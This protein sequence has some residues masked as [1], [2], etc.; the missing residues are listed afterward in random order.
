MDVDFFNAKRSNAGQNELWIKAINRKNPDGSLWYPKKSDLICSSHFVNGFPSKDFSNPDYVPSKFPKTEDQ[1]HLSEENN[2]MEY[3]KL[4]KDIK[5]DI[6]NF[7]INEISHDVETVHEKNNKC[8]QCNKEFNYSHSLYRHIRNIHEGQKNY[9]CKIC[10]QAFT[11]SSSLK[12]HITNVH[13]D[14][15]SHKCELCDQEFLHKNDLRIHIKKFHKDQIKC[16]LCNKVFLQNCNLK[17]HI[18]II[19]EGVKEFQCTICGQA[20]GQNGSLRMHIRVGF[21]LKI[22]KQQKSSIVGILV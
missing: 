1:D 4:I 22:Q 10:N 21:F 7:E 19:H 6:S 11:Q 12:T 8:D 3:E 5:E 18:K 14:G 2:D 16:H 9:E 15:K 13:N 20:F 17:R